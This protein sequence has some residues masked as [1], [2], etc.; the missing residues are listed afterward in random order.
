MNRRD[1]LI[2][3]AAVSAAGAGS[4]PAFAQG[5]AVEEA[6]L[7]ALMGGDFATATSQIALERATHPAVRS[8]AELEI[9]EQ[10]AVAEAFGSEPG[11]AGLAEEK[12]GIVEQLQA[13]EG[14]AF[15]AMYIDG[16]IAGHQELLAIHQDYAANGDDPMARGASLVGVT[17]IQSHL[18]MLE[19]I[20]QALG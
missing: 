12:A 20:R 1:I 6:K 15:D 11:A 14:A 13:A 9:A 4:L 18:V 8:F 16:Q 3:M 7:P 10:A 2:A 17:G 19:S 5:A